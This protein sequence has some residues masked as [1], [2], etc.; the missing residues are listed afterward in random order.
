VTQVAKAGAP[1]AGRVVPLAVSIDREEVVRLLGYPE[2]HALPPRLA[3]L[4]DDTLGVARGLVRGRGVFVRL[5]PDRAPEVGLRPV[6]AT[7]L[8]VGLVTV[9]EEIE[10][11]AAEASR[12]AEPTRALLLDCVGSA[13]TEEAADRLGA[14]IVGAPSAGHRRAVPCRFSPGYG[15]WALKDQPRLFALLPHAQLGVT[16]LPSMMM[17]P[18]KSVSFAMWLGAA[19]DRPA[20]RGC[21]GCALDHCR[22]RRR[23]RRPAGT[24]HHEHG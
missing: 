17:V 7:E 16:L 18:R 24:G 23:S 19:A 20:D 1:E 5:P 8:I 2:G 14:A 10:A 13:A 6:A 9:G 3:A 12:R 11:A 21:A 4:L 22:Y 15:D